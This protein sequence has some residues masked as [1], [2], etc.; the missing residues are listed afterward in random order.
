MESSL[1][2]LLQALFTGG[3]LRRFLGALPDGERLLAALPGEL[4]SLEELATSGAGLLLRHGHVTEL[5]FSCLVEAR[6]G[7]LADIEAEAAAHGLKIGEHARMR[8]LLRGHHDA[9]AAERIG[10][11]L[12]G[13]RERPGLDIAMAE[14]VRS[15][16]GEAEDVASVPPRDE[17]EARVL[18]A[19]GEAKLDEEDETGE[20]P[21][22]AAE[23]AATHREIRALIQVNRVEEAALRVL[24][25]A[26][27]LHDE[28]LDEAIVLA[29]KIRDHYRAR[30]AGGDATPEQYA[31]WVN[32]LRELLRMATT[33]AERHHDASEARV[34]GP[35]ADLAVIFRAQGISKQFHRGQRTGFALRDVALTLRPGTLTG[36]VG[37]NGAGKTTLL[38]IAAG[39]LLPD[40]GEVEYPGLD[41]RGRGQAVRWH[42]VKPQIGYLAQRVLPWH[43]RMIDDLHAWA[44]RHGMSARDNLRLTRFYLERLGLAAYAEARWHELSG[45]FQVRFELARVLLTRP[46]LLVLD[47]PLAPLDVI[48]QERFLQ[49][50]RDIIRSGPGQAVL[51]S[52]QHIHEIE[53]VA[54]DMVCLRHDGRPFT[55]P[56]SPRTQLF[57][58]A[59]HLPPTTQD[60]L[61]QRFGPGSLREQRGIYVVRTPAGL[62]L[63]ELVGLLRGAS[64][65]Y[66]RDISDSAMRLFRE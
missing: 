11:L 60:A 45:G 28:T 42:H 61:R 46:R 15:Q 56:P 57:E 14:L 35:V 18:A 16:T 58:I 31:T 48:T 23:A 66:A 41:P 59:G 37:P 40:A 47:E 54:D 22:S 39:L 20:A 7:R 13:G 29:A 65:S 4:A 24:D 43:G 27:G 1:R 30:A 19:L 64:L 21:T 6:P 49:D 36:V 63:S 50:I 44:A 17:I 26:G 53:A 5:L 62:S 9:V 38:R 2:D 10:R 33:I 52:S 8:A 32:L 51:L 34:P 25:F 3:E 12:R 55:P